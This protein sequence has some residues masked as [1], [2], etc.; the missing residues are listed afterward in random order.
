MND[1]LYHHGILGQKWGV[2]RFQNEDGSLTPAG[3]KR[4]G[5]NI[6][7]AQNKLQIAKKQYDSA[8]KQYTLRPTATSL[9]AYQKTMGRYEV[10]K[11]NLKN[12]KIKERLNN[13]KK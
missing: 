8:R 9:K 3:A 6:D 10:A 11:S 4:Y 5:V 12:E 7:E 13:E 1:T 2:R